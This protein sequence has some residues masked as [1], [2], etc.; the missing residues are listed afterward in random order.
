MQLS[1]HFHESG[2]IFAA[3]HLVRLLEALAK[4]VD[5]KTAEGCPKCKGR[6]FEPVE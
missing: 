5:A 4:P 1:P 6:R 2:V 3:R